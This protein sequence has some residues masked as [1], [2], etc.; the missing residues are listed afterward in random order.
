MPI[1]SLT[2]LRSSSMKSYAVLMNEFVLS[3]GHTC[4]LAFQRTALPH[5]F[6][7]AEQRQKE[8]SERIPE[9]DLGSNLDAA[10]F[11]ST[12]VD[13]PLSEVNICSRSE[14]HPV[15]AWLQRN[16]LIESEAARKTR[17]THSHTPDRC[18]GVRVSVSVG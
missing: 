17:E 3:I 8:L 11:T 1:R 7:M 16:G 9:P 6:F 15:V 2:L 18:H 4:P 12:G 13:K 5:E 14:I 10:L